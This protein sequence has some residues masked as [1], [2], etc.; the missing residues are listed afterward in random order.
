MVGTVHAAQTCT[1][2]GWGTQGGGQVDRAHQRKLLFN[3]YGGPAWGHTVCMLI[4]L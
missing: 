4:L 3:A 1:V 2:H